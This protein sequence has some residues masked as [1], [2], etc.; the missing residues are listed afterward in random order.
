MVCLVSNSYVW[1]VR[2][3][4]RKM[5]SRMEVG[6]TSFISD[7]SSLLSPCHPLN[8]YPPTIPNPST[9]EPPTPTPTSHPIPSHRVLLD[10]F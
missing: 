3:V 1:L 9:L 4:M 6:K 2:N 10:K 7:I 8:P 5:T